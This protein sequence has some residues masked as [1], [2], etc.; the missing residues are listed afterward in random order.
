MI[1]IEEK[2][3][4]IFGTKNYRMIITKAEFNGGLIVSFQDGKPNAWNGSYKVG[5][6]LF[7][8]YEEEEFRFLGKQKTKWIIENLAQLS[9]NI[10]MAANDKKRWQPIDANDS[11]IQQYRKIKAYQ[12]RPYEE[13]PMNDFEHL[14]Y[15][16]NMRHLEHPPFDF[17]SVPVKEK[18]EMD[19]PIFS[20][21]KKFGGH[22]KTR[23]RSGGNAI[24]ENQ[25]F[26][27]LIPNLPDNIYLQDFN[28]HL[29]QNDFDKIIFSLYLYE[30]NDQGIQQSLLAEPITFEATF[31]GWIKLGLQEYN[32]R[33]SGDVLAVL[34][35]SKL[36]GEVGLDYIFFSTAQRS[37]N[38]FHDRTNQEWGIWEE[39]FAWY[40]NIQE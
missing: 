20:N 2:R 37:Y 11:K 32:L 29:R 18:K 5:D 15:W 25:K 17:S 27:T 34:E 39:N 35:L 9:G 40:L 12:Y 24:N 16:K 6:P 30:V 38:S 21:N 7:L 13:L 36:E 1:I 26:G 14:P 3:K 22:R 8:Y 10:Y 28:F 4:T 31:E 33:A 19:Q 23:T